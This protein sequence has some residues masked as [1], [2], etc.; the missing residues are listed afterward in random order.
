MEHQDWTEVRVHRKP[1]ASNNLNP[2]K[3]RS[4]TSNSNGKVVL[5]HQAALER[6]ILNSEEPIKLKKLSLDSRKLIAQK[7][8]ELQLSQQQLNTSCALPLNYIRDIEA[9]KV[10]PTPSQLTNINRILKTSIKLELLS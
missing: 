8:A 3:L 1:N 10:I 7:R 9:G 6:K 4:D 5:S 2:G